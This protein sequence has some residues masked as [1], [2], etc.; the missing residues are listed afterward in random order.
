MDD[1]IKRL[2]ALTL[3]SKTIYVLGKAE[4]KRINDAISLQM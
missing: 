3:N 4:M 1:T 2:N